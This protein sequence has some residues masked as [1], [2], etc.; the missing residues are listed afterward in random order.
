[1]KGY[2][3][4]SKIWIFFEMVEKDHTSIF[5]GMAT[6]KKVKERFEKSLT[7]EMRIKNGRY[8]TKNFWSVEESFPNHLFATS[9]FSPEAVAGRYYLVNGRA[10][11]GD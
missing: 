10:V 4:K 3:D 9:M 1:M 8:K 11:D 5:R 2:G 7:E 6:T